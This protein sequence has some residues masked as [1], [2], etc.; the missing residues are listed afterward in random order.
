MTQRWGCDWRRVA[1]ACALLLACL[2]WSGRA[3]AE[4]TIHARLDRFARSYVLHTDLT[5]TET[6]QVDCTLLDARG[7]AERERSAFSF[8]P[9]S[10]SLQVVEAWVEEPDGTRIDVPASGRFTRPS[11]AAQNAPGFTGAMTT[12]LLFPQLR[13][14][15]RTH[16]V[17]R[18]TQR[19]PPVSGFNIWAEPPLGTPV[20]LGEIKIAAPAALGL[21]WAAR[22]GFAVS[23]RSE[24]G[25][26]VITATIRDTHA[27]E[28]EPEMVSAS[29][30]QPLFLLTSLSR[31]Q[32]IGALY[33]RQ[34]HAKAVVTPEI[35]ALAARL[36]GGRTDEAAARAIYDWVTKNIRYVA[37]YLDPDDGWVP[38]SAPDVLA[39][40]YGDCKDHVVLM[41][42]LLGSLGIRS[43]A[44]LVDWGDEMKPAPLWV[45][46]FNHAILYLPQYDR[47]LNPTNP[48][49]RYGTLDL[50]LAGKLTVLATQ[51]GAVG[52]TPPDTP[53]G[54]VYRMDSQTVLEPDGTIDG[55]ARF[56]LS[57]NL[58]SLM[59]SAVAS[60]ESATQ[61]PDRLLAGTPEGGFGRFSSS[62]PRDL[63][64]PFSLVATWRSPHAVSFADQQAFMTAPVGPDPDP[65]SRLR[66]FLS[67]GIRHHAMIVGAGDYTWTDTVRLP[68]SV[69]VTMLPRDVTLRNGAGSYQ[70]NYARSDSGLRITRHLVIARD[71]YAA[72]DYPE[73]ETLLYAA[74]RDARATMVLS[75]PEAV[76]WSPP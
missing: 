41:Q 30:F 66:R 71:V 59:R 37:V 72:R 54:N 58:E 69:A 2:S 10:Q 63:S 67:R 5:Y 44:A 73:L 24:A 18:L 27:A 50:H 38:H 64:Q 14:G 36:A 20:G 43:E 35:S 60:A 47:Y 42:A 13:E 6:V 48:Y 40:G 12:T 17:W 46:Q 15:S 56:V 34:S 57:A 19:K 7:I 25:Q 22:G 1:G 33:W 55:S 61:L 31:L 11:A 52:H 39:R 32:D 74:L 75:R 76:A 3:G 45:P 16:V 51:D 62:N 70:A 29:D 53:A 26:R 9:A 21:H 23:D 28:A 49:A 4:P 68:P 65:L 8:Y